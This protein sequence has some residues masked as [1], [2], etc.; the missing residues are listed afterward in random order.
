MVLPRTLCRTVPSFMRGACLF[1]WGVWLTMLATRLSLTAKYASSS[2][3]LAD[4]WFLLDVAPRSFSLSWLWEQW[5]EHRVPVAKAIWLGALRLTDYDFRFGNFFLILAWAAMAAGMI[6]VSKAIRGRTSYSDAFFPLALLTLGQGVNFFWWW[7]VNQMIAPLVACILL[8]IIVLRGKDLPPRLALATAILLVLLPLCG[9]GG[10]P[11]VVVLA[12]WL[13]HWSYRHWSA[14]NRIHPHITQVVLALTVLALLLVAAYFKGLRLGGW[15]VAESPR[16][17]VRTAVQLLSVSFGIAA[18]DHWRVLGFGILALTLLSAVLLGAIWARQPAERSRALGLLL[19]LGAV[20]SLALVVAKARSG[21]SEDYIFF[22]TYVPLM[23]PLLCCAYF[24]SSLYIRPTMGPLI[25][26]SLF[27][28][29][30]ILLIGNF[31]DVVDKG[32]WMSS[33][34]RAMENDLDRGIPA[35]I[36]AE[37]HLAPEIYHVFPEDRIVDEAAR[38]LGRLQKAGVGV[39]AHMRANPELREVPLL[40]APTAMNR[41]VWKAGVAYGQAGG[42]GSP[43]LVFSLGERRF[44]YA[45]RLRFSHTDTA[46]SSVMLGMSWRAQGDDEPRH[47]GSSIPGPQFQLRVS[48]NPARKLLKLVDGEV[49]YAPARPENV[50]TVWVNSRIDHIQIYPDTKPCVFHLSEI[51]LLVPESDQSL[52]PT[53]QRFS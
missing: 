15:P 49:R 32:Q 40:V 1:V 18:R 50:V 43:A 23:V 41:I 26:V 30:A 39:F 52:L 33:R 42:E 10:L 44:V 11:Y 9:P 46:G 22:G 34:S 24:V 17:F 25:E 47:T 53:S 4:E 45:V 5:A 29:A 13:A 51:R 12:V 21:M 3:P 6:L 27:S 19:F 7:A 37:R 14:P 35:F 48:V 20:C 36:L 8:M 28:L 2:I 38:L 31:D 16:A